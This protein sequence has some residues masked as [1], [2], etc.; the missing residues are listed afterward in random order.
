MP[1]RRTAY[2]TLLVLAL[3]TGLAGYFAAQLRFNYNFNDFYPAGDP[4]L[5]YYQG[6]TRRFG[7]DNDYLLLGLEAGPG[8]T[9][10]SPAFLTQVDSLTRLAR[11][12]RNVL[13]VSSPTT[14]SQTIVEGLGAYTLPTCT[15]PT[16]APTPAAAPPTPP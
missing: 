10:F 4:D 5:D 16:T 15:R 3:L 9:A 13:H 2:L 6:Y 12:Q 8:Q 7:N 14:L 11:R 1:L